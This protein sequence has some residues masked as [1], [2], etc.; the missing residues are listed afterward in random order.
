MRSDGVRPEAPRRLTHAP[1]AKLHPLMYASRMYSDRA[2]NIVGAFALAIHDRLE[3]G[4]H[5]RDRRAVPDAALVHLSHCS[6]PTIDS[7]R[8]VLGLTHSGAV[9]LADRLERD[10]LAERA[11]GT[12]DRRVTSLRLTSRGAAAVEAVL[13]RRA[14]ALHDL[15][16]GALSAVEQATLADLTGKLLFAATTGPNDLYRICRLCEFDACPDCPVAAASAE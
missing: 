10:T 5:R 3:P 1:L 8:A 7:L 13:S 4:A 2:S 14:D 9:R 11:P 16:Q 12:N 15:M 6:N